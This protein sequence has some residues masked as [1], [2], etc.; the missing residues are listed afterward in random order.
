MTAEPDKHLLTQLKTREILI[1]TSNKSGD[2][3]AFAHPQKIDFNNPIKAIH[4]SSTRFNFE[5]EDGSIGINLNNDQSEFKK[6][7]FNPA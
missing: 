7:E 2:G 4:T 5:T 3:S 1:P 6:T